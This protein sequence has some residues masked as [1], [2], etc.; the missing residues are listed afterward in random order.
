M[1]DWS[2]I[3]KAKKFMMCEYTKDFCG[4]NKM[5]KLFS[6]K[7]KN[8]LFCRLRLDKGLKKGNEDEQKRHKGGD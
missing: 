3:A 2:D 1:K 8:Y 6:R 4:G 7:E 5:W